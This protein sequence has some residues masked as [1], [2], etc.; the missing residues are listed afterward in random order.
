M[1]ACQT[2]TACTANQ[3]QFASTGAAGC[4]NAP[5]DCPQPAG[6]CLDRACIANQCATTP[7]ANCSDD[8]GA[9]VD[10]GRAPTEDLA[11]APDLSASLSVTGGGGC[12]LAGH[13]AGGGAPAPLAFVVLVALLAFARRRSPE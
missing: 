13:G 2:A 9:V 10:L 3:C 8:G 7:V 1:N 6:S 11:T 12:T 5:S 4:C